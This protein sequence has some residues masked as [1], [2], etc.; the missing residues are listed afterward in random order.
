MNISIDGRLFEWDDAKNK[1]NKIKH[2]ITFQTAVLV[3]EDE[4]R[5]ED[6]D[7]YN[8]FYR[9]CWKVLG[10][11][12]NVHVVVYSDR[13]DFTKI[14]SARKATPKEMETYKIMSTVNFF[15][16]KGSKPTLEQK[17]ELASLGKQQTITFDK[18]CMTFPRELDWEM[19]R[20][21][22]KYRTRRI[23]KEIWRS[24]HP[25]GDFTVTYD[26]NG[27]LPKLW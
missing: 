7:F 6:Y 18:D 5:I 8:S 3:F 19:M 27:N 15:L 25:E 13:E 12:E 23:T 20:L 10:A 24:E 1:I 9:D 2:S 17:T 16:P 4:F 21:H 11:I 14:I 22:I 26:E